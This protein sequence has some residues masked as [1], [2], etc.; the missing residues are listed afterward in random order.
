MMMMIGLRI[1]SLMILAISLWTNLL[2]AQK[3]I[4]GR[5]I[6]ASNGDPIPYSNIWILGTNYGTTSLENGNFSLKTDTIITNKVLKISSVGYNDTLLKITELHKVI[7]LNPK[8]YELTD[9]KIYPNKKIEFI[10]NDL[11]NTTLKGAITNDTTPRIIGMYFPYKSNYYNYP[12]VKSILIYT[13]DEKHRKFNIRIYGFDTISHKPTKELIA[14]NILVKSNISLLGKPK[15]VE[16]NLIDY[17]IKI[18]ESGIFI[19]IEWLILPEN[20]F[21]IDYTNLDSK[22]KFWRTHYG[23]HLGATIDSVNFTWN[24]LKGKWSEP[25]E[26]RYLRNN[27]LVKRHF[28]PAISIKLTN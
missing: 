11:R 22:K 1:T 14:K 6:D 16:V 5:I 3:S 25:R 20:K 27:A 13:S 19:G 18:P 8:V 24:Y 4:S 17:S 21:R 15:Y 2:F 9:V 7:K 26:G 23:P 10:V 28:N 12:Y